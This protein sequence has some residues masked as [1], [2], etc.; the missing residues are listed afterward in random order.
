MYQDLSPITPGHFLVGRPLVSLPP[1]PNM[2]TK[3]IS[4]RYQ[5]MEQIR[6]HFRNR[7]H[8]EYLSELQ[9]RTKWKIRQKDLKLGDF[10]VFKDE[11]LPPLKWKLGRVHQIYTG[12]HGINR[13]AD[14]ITRTHRGIERRAL[15]KVCPLPVDIDD[16]EDAEKAATGGAN[17]KEEAPVEGDDTH[18]V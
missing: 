2:S 7:W 4:I 14:F 1:P 11:N 8:N 17:G 13:V 9:Q 15:N 18:E 10:V 3:T 5:M 16:N 12:A 6:N